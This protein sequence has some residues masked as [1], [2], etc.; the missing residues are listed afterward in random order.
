MLNAQSNKKTPGLYL[1]LPWAM[2]TPKTVFFSPKNL[3]VE[4]AINVETSV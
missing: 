1:F 2:K 4:K 3:I